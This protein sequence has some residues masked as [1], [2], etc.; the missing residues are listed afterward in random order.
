MR[1]ISPDGHELP[2]ITKGTLVVNGGGMATLH[3]EIHNVEVDVEIDEKNVSASITQSTL[4][5]SKLA[6]K[7]DVW[8]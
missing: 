2:N 8:H 3:V 1:L 4:R 5:G 6:T 7:A